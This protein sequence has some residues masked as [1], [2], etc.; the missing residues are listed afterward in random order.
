MTADE[1]EALTVENGE[2]RKAALLNK[3]VEQITLAA[4][5][6]K[7]H[8]YLATACYYIDDQL[9]KLGYKTHFKD[10]GDMATTKY[11]VSWGGFIG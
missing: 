10:T 1:A 11:M 7:R 3:A 9:L 6:G 5:G 4:K 2:E 8:A